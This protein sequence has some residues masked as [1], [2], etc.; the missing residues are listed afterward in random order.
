MPSFSQNDTKDRKT[1]SIKNVISGCFRVLS[2]RRKFERNGA[3]GGGNV[4]Y[5]AG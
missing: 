3:I 2:F 1:F 4:F 5:L